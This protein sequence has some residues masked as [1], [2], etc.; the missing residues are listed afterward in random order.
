MN[1]K[2]T[3]KNLN[4]KFKRALMCLVLLAVPMFA[5]QAEAQSRLIV[6]DSLGLP[7]L[8]LT[9]LL[10]NC[11][12]GNSLGD[13]QGQ[14]FVV[15]FPTI[16]NPLTA[17]LK[18]NVN[19]IGILSVEIDQTVNAKQPNAGATPN[20]LTDKSPASYYGSTV[21]HGYLV[22]PGNQL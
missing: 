14:L 8:K 7:G 18:L 4:S 1:T 17:L 20:Y 3:S 10:L 6:R 9:C 13:P 12:V 22:Q 5:S 16:L 15:T 2:L 11:K 21:W 19:V